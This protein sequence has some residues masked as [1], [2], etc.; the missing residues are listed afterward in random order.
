MSALATLGPVG[1][2]LFITYD[3]MLTYG[4][5]PDLN[6]YKIIASAAQ[7]NS[8]AAHSAAVDW[9]RMLNSRVRPDVELMNTLIRCCEMCGEWERD[10]LFL[11]LLS[12][13]LSPDMD[14]FDALFKVGHCMAVPLIRY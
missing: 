7:T 10:F 5:E 2:P 14:T 9:W 3:D 4:V 12:S 8:T 6:M 1:G 11:G 13:Q